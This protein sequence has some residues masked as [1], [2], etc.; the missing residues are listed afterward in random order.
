MKRPTIVD[1]ARRVGVSKAA[2]SYALNGRE[3]VSA[4]TRQQI[5]D[6]AEQMGWRASN[7]ARALSSD[8]TASIGFVFARPPELLR[9]EPFFM[10]LLVGM[11]QTLSEHGVSLQLALAADSET[12]LATYRRWWA[13]RRVD[14]MLLTDLRVSDPRPPLLR[15]LGAPAVA[16]GAPGEMTGIPVL[17]SAELS[18]VRQ[19]VDHLAAAGHRHI[20]HVLGSWELLHTRRRS[21]ALREAIQD[22][23][24]TAVVAADGGYTERG[25]VAATRE[26]LESEPRPSAVVYDNDVMAVAAA[27]RAGELGV[28]VPDDLA[29]VAWDDSMLCRVVEPAVTAFDHDVVGDAATAVRQLL[30]LIENGVADDVALSRRDLI[31]RASSAGAR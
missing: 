7:A 18:D 17:R 30:E 23:L 13:E 12:E 19:I 26:V 2:V 11:E 29:I 28:R 27:A 3:G 16:F 21:A 25:G 15:E 31:V 8:R 5:L 1:I 10:R 4:E 14:G 22:R 24:G 9:T 20:G 6:V